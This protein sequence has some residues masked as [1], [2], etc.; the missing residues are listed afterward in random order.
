MGDVTRLRRAVNDGVVIG[1]GAATSDL[2][3]LSDRCGAS[4][5]LVITTPSVERSPLL[6]RVVEAL[7]D[8]HVATFAGSRAHTPRPVVVAAAAAA[9]D[10]GADGLVSLGG[11]SVVD[12]TKGV[13]MVLAEGERFE[14]LRVGAG[15]R[16]SAPK[17]PHIAVP[18]T[19][20][21]AEF[22]AGAG[23]TDPETGV[24]ELFASATLAP[25]WVVLDATMTTATPDRLWA[26][27]GMKLVADC[28]EGL[29][30]A[31][32][33]EYSTALLTAALAI[34]LRDLAAP[35]A[36]LEA[37]S[38]CLEAAHMTLSNL[39]NVGVGAVAALRHQ[40]GGRCGVAHG[41]ASTIVLPH[42]MRWNG[43]AAAPAL[44][45]AA[46]AIGLDDGGG[47]IDRMIERTEALGLPTRLRDVGVEEAQLDEIA[48]HAG[49]EFSARRNVRPATAA[50]LRQILDAA[51]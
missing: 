26:G 23:I 2:P 9:R 49:A 42:V 29:V 48:E 17:L 6:H 47:L 18:T 21:A 16:L 13:A 24:K 8:R 15:H 46:R 50:D 35:A 4:R 11:S 38:R 3:A 36:D 30:S 45:R 37:R 51:W 40:L 5:V 19:L 25:R 22:T 12:L 10:A 43:E 28:L 31:R 20:S 41:E 27:T 7:G 44:D 33:T 32:S 14:T 39:H 34:L 1:L